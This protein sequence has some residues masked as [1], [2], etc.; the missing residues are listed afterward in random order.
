MCQVSVQVLLYLW[1]EAILK[2]QLQKE[3]GNS[4]S[5]INEETGY[6][7]LLHFKMPTVQ[8]ATQVPD[9]GWRW[10]QCTHF[11]WARGKNPISLHFYNQEISAQLLSP[12]IFYT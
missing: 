11:P 10:D 3:G 4:Y 2:G 5:L 8:C 12:F 6:S 9:R 7:E 1:I